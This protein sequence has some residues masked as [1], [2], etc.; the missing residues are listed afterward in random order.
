MKKLKSK[1]VNFLYS[2]KLY[3][4][5]SQWKDQVPSGTLSQQMKA[6]IINHE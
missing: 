5:R 2:H 6:K 1:L 4:L 3:F